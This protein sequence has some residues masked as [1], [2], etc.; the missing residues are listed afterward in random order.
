MS[1]KNRVVALVSAITITATSMGYAGSLGDFVKSGTGETYKMFV[2]NAAARERVYKNDAWDNNYYTHSFEILRREFEDGSSESYAGANK[3][4]IDLVK[5]TVT[6]KVVPPDA[7]AWWETEPEVDI[8]EAYYWV[9]TD[10]P[11]SSDARASGVIDT[12]T[13]IDLTTSYFKSLPKTVTIPDGEDTKTITVESQNVVGISGHLASTMPY[14][15]EIKVGS[16]LLYIDSEALADLQYITDMEFPDTLVSI[17]SGAFANSGIK[18]VKFNSKI[19]AI[20]N[21]CFANTKLSDVTL[22]YPTSLEYIGEGAFSNTVVTSFPFTSTASELVIGTNAFSGCTQ[23]SAVTLP[24]TV[25]SIGAGAFEGCSAAKSVSI[26]KNTRYIGDAAF[27]NMSSL[28][29]ITLNSVLESVGN[30]LFANNTSLVTGPELP[31]TVIMRCESSG[32]AVS[33][34]AIPDITLRRRVIESIGE[35]ISSTGMFS[36]CTVLKTVKLPSKLTDIPKSTFEDCISLTTPTIGSKID[37]VRESAFAN[38]KN[39]QELKT[40][41]N[42]NR[43]YG[44]AFSGCTSL[45]DVSFKTINILDDGAYSGCT[46]LK[47]LDITV[48]EYLGNSAFSG[49][50]GLKDVNINT[51]TSGFVWGS[52]VFANCTQ[53]ETAYLDLARANFIPAG[54]FAGDI[55]LTSLKDTNLNNIEL[56][57]TDAF[58]GCEALEQLALPKV[59][60]VED[61]AFKDCKKLKKI[62]SGDITIKDYGAGSFENCTSLT[63]KI[64]AGVSTIGDNAFTN[65][66]ITA[67]KITGTDG[68]TLVIDN[69]AF[70]QCTN[71]KTV[72]I[73]IPDGVEYKIGNGIFEGSVNIESA[74]YNGTEI[75][76]AMFRGCSKLSSLSLPRAVDVL[77]NAFSGCENLKTI[78]GVTAFGSIR[79]GAFANCSSLQKTYANKSTTFYGTGQYENCTGIKEADVYYLTDSMFEGCTALAKVNL[80]S[81][82]TIIPEKAFLGC[83]GLKSINLDKVKDFR[84]NCMSSTGIEEL[85]LSSANTIDAEAFS[86]CEQLSHIDIEI[87]DIGAGAF[88]GC[89][90]LSK[91]ALTVNRLENNVFNGCSSLIDMTFVTG[92]GYSL[93]EVG[94]GAFE[95]TMMDHVVIPNT[96]T[97]IGSSAFGIGDNG[98]K[99]NYVI[100]GTPG[101]EA[102][103][104]ANDNEIQFKDVKTYNK[105][106]ILKQRTKLGDVN[107][108]GIIS[109]ADAVK[110]QSWLLAKP[111]GSIGIYGPNMDLTQDGR[112]DAFDMILMRRKLIEEMNIEEPEE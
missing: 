83:T 58:Y 100:Y 95:G 14:L 82:I 6:H 30:N 92:N 97:Y 110:L 108:D 86:N 26:G 106:A 102:E 53:L 91:A 19:T 101:T 79:G 35:E 49:C 15:K 28:K 62:C 88:T 70:S 41:E 43:I 71:L 98:K 37:T 105:S 3:D 33:E 29:T 94:D 22:K 40:V 55:R 2:A 24:D 8:E 32:Y 5:M 27:A 56:V 16:G 65:S 12:R 51:G 69:G 112:V 60:I 31:D 84:T 90:S 21:S 47:S 68:N 52:S 38:C 107:M 73:N 87:D 64:N 23:M 74:T 9:L 85:K 109:I 57:L 18:S 89:R 77:E 10:N 76:E 104:Y 11:G 81:N 75:P 39:L 4:Y 42:A 59:V 80:A 1:I 46:T 93:I 61:N 103:T 17:G 78:S 96:V 63:Q 36:G 66:A 111:E 48:G 45:R 13:S 99:E 54:I 50:T 34:T 7:E 72:E 25:Y 44:G 20:P 67:V